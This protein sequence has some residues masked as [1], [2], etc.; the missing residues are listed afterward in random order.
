MNTVSDL[1]KLNV[2][3]HTEKKGGLT[4]L[5]WA[6]AWAEALKSD[7][8]A[9]FE[10]QLFGEPQSPV[11][12]IADTGMVFVNV[13]M[14]GKTL[15][16]HLPVMDYKNKAIKNPDAF[17]VNT[18]I[19]RALTKGLALHGLGLY[20]YAGEDLPQDAPPNKGGDPV[21]SFQDTPK[22]DAFRDLQ[23][24]IQ[25]FMRNVAGQVTS[26][27][28]NAT[29]AIDIIELALEQWPN[30][31]PNQLKIALWHLLDSKTR[32]AIKLAQREKE[33]A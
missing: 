1:L 31:D 16:C 3:E 14:F 25:A 6:W 8:K 5:S 30:E 11:C 21:E 4:Y 29:R 2:N 26:S 7:P 22:A 15:T 23:P 33:T 18:A 10:I 17:A 13:T 32:A 12:Y 19:Q 27:M 24:E 28:P 20:I 9:S